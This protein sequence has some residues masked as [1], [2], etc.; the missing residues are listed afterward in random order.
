[1]RGCEECL[2]LEEAK[3]DYDVFT[4]FV[5]LSGGCR[6]GRRAFLSEGAGAA[7]PR[8]S[9]CCVAGTLIYD[10]VLYASSPGI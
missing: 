6:V 4:E 1:M 2:T 9:V 5:L 7:R 10:A 8:A 3:G